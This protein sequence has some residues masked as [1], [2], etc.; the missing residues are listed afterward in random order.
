MF[1]PAVY[2]YVVSFSSSGVIGNFTGRF[3][4]ADKSMALVSIKRLWPSRAVACCVGTPIDTRFNQEFVSSRMGP[5]NS[6]NAM[7]PTG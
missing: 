7:S 1:T 6:P 3:K 4:R 5:R 2:N